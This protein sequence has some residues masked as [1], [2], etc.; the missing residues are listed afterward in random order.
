MNRDGRNHY[1]C[2][3]A[4]VSI[5]MQMFIF[6]A[7]HFD[8]PGAGSKLVQQVAI[9]AGCY[10]VG[11]KFLQR[12]SSLLALRQASSAAAKFWP[13]AYM[14][15]LWACKCERGLLKRTVA[16]TEQPGMLAGW[17]NFAFCAPAK[18]DICYPTRT[19]ANNIAARAACP[20]F[21]F[22]KF[23]IRLF[24]ACNGWGGGA[25][26]FLRRR[27]YFRFMRKSVVSSTNTK[28]RDG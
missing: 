1:N 4:L 18:Y 6:G 3:A 15:V 26:P 2:L 7:K 16:H 10:G 27:A 23:Y 9:S 25:A 8:T 24:C 5:S 17:L 19:N 12:S 20:K 13:S 22:D 21:P 11:R 14:C 28:A